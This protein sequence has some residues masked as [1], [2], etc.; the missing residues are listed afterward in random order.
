VQMSK[1]ERME[2][3]TFALEVVG[4]KDRLHH[5]PSQLSGGQEQRVAIARAIVTDPQIIIADEPTGDLDRASATEVLSLI[6]ALNRDFRKTVVI[7]THDPAAAEFA[8]RVV[9]FDKGKLVD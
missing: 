1:R 8:Q 9:H 5:L 7:V 6:S 3:A 2:R 4:L